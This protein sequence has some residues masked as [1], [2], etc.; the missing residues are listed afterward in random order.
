MRL[1]GS[2]SRTYLTVLGSLAIFFSTQHPC[3]GQETKVFNSEVKATAKITKTD[4]GK[5]TVT[6][7]VFI[8][9]GWYIYANPV[10]NPKD[11]YLKNQ[12]VVRVN[13]KGK[14][15]NV[16]IQ[17]PAG[18]LH[19]EFGDKYMIYHDKATIEVSVQREVGDVSPLEV[20]LILNTCHLTEM[21]CLPKSQ[22]KFFLP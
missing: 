22:K 10:Q 12:T 17:F 8:N 9:H 13:A 18:E 5:Q 6:L 2:N 14:L 1:E 21:K 3:L 19:E 20:D 15:S 4:A 7:T 16:K 11:D